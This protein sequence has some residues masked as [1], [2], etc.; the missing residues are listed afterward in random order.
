[1]SKNNTPTPTPKAGPRRTLPNRRRSEARKIKWRP[2]HNVDAPETTIHVTIGYGDDGLRPV[3][4]F[5]DAGYR[6]GSDRATEISDLC[7]M[8]SVFIQHEGVTIDSLMRP[9]AQEKD[10]RSGSLEFGSTVGVLL[11][12]LKTPPAWAAQMD[13][14][15]ADD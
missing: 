11:E 8:I 2:P 7:I 1:M 5:Y 3:E 12:Q 9:L 4:I 14:E 10:A 13:V 6:S 15:V